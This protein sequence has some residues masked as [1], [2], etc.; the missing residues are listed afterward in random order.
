M[1]LN[2]TRGSSFFFGKVAA[3][4]VLSCFALYGLACFFLPSFYMYI[5]MYM[6]ISCMYIYMYILYVYKLMYMYM[7]IHR[8]STTYMYL[9]SAVEGE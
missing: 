9:C 5:Y 2:P 4:G 3:L 6:Y 8:V 1:G 7:Y